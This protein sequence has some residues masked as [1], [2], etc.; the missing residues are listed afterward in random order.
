MARIEVRHAVPDDAEALTEVT[1][2]SIREICGASGDYTPE[3]IEDWLENKTPTNFLKWMASS[4]LR[5][6]AGLLNDQIA[7]VGMFSLEGEIELL[8]LVPE[9]RG[10][11]LGRA[12]LAEIESEAEFREISP[13]RLH[14]TTVAVNFYE[15]HGYRNLGPSALSLRSYDMEKAM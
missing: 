15:R 6:Y 9:A 3:Q 4:D 7:G 14:A 10:H 2:R 8:Y 5:L 1:I 11:G 13:L 12:L